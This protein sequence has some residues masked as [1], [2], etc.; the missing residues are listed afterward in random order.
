MPAVAAVEADEKAARGAGKGTHAGED[1]RPCFA[2]DRLQ[3]RA[4]LIA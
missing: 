3:Q 4:A 1:L 2:V